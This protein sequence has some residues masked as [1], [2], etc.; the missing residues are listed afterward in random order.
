MAGRAPRSILCRYYLSYSCRAGN[1]CRFSHDKTT[2]ILPL[3]R[4]FETG[5]CRHGE[6][7]R[8][9]HVSDQA[10]SAPS[11]SSSGAQPNEAPVKLCELHMISGAC[12]IKECRA[13]H[14]RLCKTCSMYV[15]HPSNPALADQHVEECRR[16]CR[17]QK[18]SASLLA[19]SSQLQCGIC[20]DVVLE[21]EAESSRIFGVLE[22]CSHVFCWDCIRQW[23]KT[24]TVCPKVARGCPGC[25]T[26]S[27]VVVPS[28]YFVTEGERKRT[29]IES[30]KIALSK[31]ECKLFDQGRGIC[32]FA[33]RCLSRHALPDGTILPKSGPDDRE[34]EP[35]WQYLLLEDGSVAVIAGPVGSR[36]VHVIPGPSQY[37]GYYVRV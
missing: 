25:R 18:K 8:Y 24:K 27:F 7:C 19:R 17:E 1:R 35:S 31:K 22:E 28:A 10:D 20:L 3:C 9:R 23:R 34:G 16:T 33:S 37:G 29:L 15:L 13:I 6:R 2:G 12:R 32:P 14:G 30:F 4:Y 36:L 26:E 11:P 5:L 21:K